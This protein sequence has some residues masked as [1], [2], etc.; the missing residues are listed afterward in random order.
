MH[1]SMCMRDI[2]GKGPVHVKQVLFS[3][4]RCSFTIFMQ[5]MTPKRRN[6]SCKSHG[7]YWAIKILEF[8]HSMSKGRFFIMMGASP[9][10][11]TYLSPSAIVR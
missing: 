4:Y 8:F 5:A 9:R 11:Q 10:H 3:Y 7:N 1:N 2:V 6:V